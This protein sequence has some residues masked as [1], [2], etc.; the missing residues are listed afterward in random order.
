M[1]K[2]PKKPT[3]IGLR[4]I[5]PRDI[6]QVCKM[7]NDY[8]FRFKLSQVFTEEECS[9]WFLKKEDIVYCYVIESGN[10]ITDML[11]FYHIPHVVNNIYHKILR[12]AYSFYN[13]ANTIPYRTLILNSLILSKSAKFDV[14]NILD[15]MDNSSILQDLKFN[16]GTGVLQYH[17]YGYNHKINV[18]SNDIG[19]VLH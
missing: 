7:I 1:Y 10:K 14:F 19:I 16:I 3:I 9:H 6:P 12:I 13:V 11:S 18:S 5:E 4:K 8:L 17:V 15:L 2:L